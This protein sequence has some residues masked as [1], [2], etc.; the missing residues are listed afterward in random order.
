MERSVKK[1][2][3]IY[4]IA[5]ELGISSKELIAKLAEMGMP[6]LYPANSVGEEEY[7]LILS[8]YQDEVSH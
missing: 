8:L 1:K 2:K 5:R 7:D 4:E 6:S 3:R